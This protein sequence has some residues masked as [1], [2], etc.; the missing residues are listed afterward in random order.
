M[1]STCPRCQR[2]FDD[3]VRFCPVDGTL[4]TAGVDDRNLGQV[5]L[6]QFEVRDVCG[7]GA[8]GTVYRAYQRTMDRVVAV[9]ILRRELLKEPE[10]VRRF[11]REARAAAKLQHPNIVTVHLVGET[12]DGLP[13]IVMEHI[14]G[15]AL[16]AICEAQGP[17]SPERT[18]HIAKQIA[19]A[20][21][22][23]H[24]AGIVHRDLKPANILITDRSRVPDLVKVLDFGIA[25]IIHG[26][27]QSVLTRDGMIFGT[28]HYIA[29]EQAT[30][31][32]IDH[33]ADL[34]SL[35]IIL[36]RLAT[37]RLPVEGTAG[38]Q[39]VLKHLR[40]APPKPSAIDPLVPPL[41]EK[42]ILACLQKDRAQRPKDAEAVL[43]ELDRILATGLP[44]KGT[45]LGVYPLSPLSA[46]AATP[47]I[48]PT[49]PAPG[50]PSKPAAASA[51]T[52]KVRAVRPVATPKAA[53]SKTTP[54]ATRP[55][56]RAPRAWWASGA[57]LGGG[58]G[59]IAVGALLGVGGALWH[60]QS[61][62]AV[63]LP[64]AEAAMIA[65]PPTVPP[66]PALLDERVLTEAG[67]TLRTGFERT[68]AAGESV[69]LTIVLSDAAGPV[70]DAKV[71][72]IVRPPSGAEERVPAASPGAKGRYRAQYKFPAS[73]RFKLRIEAT[74]S[75][76]KPIAL[77]Y[78]VDAAGDSVANRPDKADKGDKSEARHARRAELPVTVVPADPPPPPRRLAGPVSVS[79]PS[80]GPT[81][82]A[83]TTGASTAPASGSP[84][85]GDAPPATPAPS[86]AVRTVVDHP[87]PIRTPPPVA[88]EPPPDDRPPP[89]AADPTT[90]PLPSPE[91]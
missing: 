4:V 21:A 16:E 59:A 12:D 58:L 70:G 49:M 3:G 10:V 1:S 88:D 47:L 42:L 83:G 73:G 57:L 6:N 35:G 78:D 8:M 23:A 61:E 60:N 39:V 65:P 9:K 79:H 91:Q 74:P 45:L 28:P 53:T 24:D 40:E 14:D 38:M 72:V 29:P 69:G 62:P 32:E 17:Q 67:F 5:L 15:V 76:G 2:L 37:G 55:P 48:S 13:F 43:A 18:I 68:P 22:E 7:R 20:L 27:D 54:E 25:K 56:K 34:Y 33:R 89:S 50:A 52:G 80:S 81:V 90:V 87:R 75:G 82:A 31:S 51:T 85:S 71:E 11:L 84:G 44:A 66:L 26:A 36:F 64:V 86:S 41:L 19:G 63:A 77:A 30:G 46:V